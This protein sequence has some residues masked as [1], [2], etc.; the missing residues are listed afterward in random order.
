M[1]IISQSVRQ[2]VCVSTIYTLK[3]DIQTHIYIY[4][5]NRCYKH[6]YMAIPTSILK[7]GLKMVL[8]PEKWMELQPQNLACRYNLTLGITWG[9][10]L[11]V[12][13]LSLCITLKNAKNGTSK[14]TNFDLIACSLS[15]LKPTR[16][17]QSRYF[18]NYRPLKV[19]QRTVHT[20]GFS[21]VP[22]NVKSLSVC[23]TSNSSHSFGQMTLNFFGHNVSILTYFYTD[24][25]PL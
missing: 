19:G 15:F 17:H 4:I 8:L 11:L 1:Q 7:K 16:C 3:L 18:C 9:G 6:V 2:S 14:K 20:V 24:T 10:S 23:L 22:I 21:L 12:T 5:Q 13:P 25:F